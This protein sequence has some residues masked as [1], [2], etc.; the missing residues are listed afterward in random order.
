MSNKPVAIEFLKLASGGQ[1]VEAYERYVASDFKHHNPYFSNDRQSL[2]DGMLQSAAA[3]PNKS[4]EIIQAVED[5]DTV[6]VHSRLTRDNVGVQYAVVHILRFEG[7]K[8][9]EMWDIAQE[10]PGDSPNEVGMF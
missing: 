1:V 4:F 5:S 10:V 8:I 3:E 2:I 6:A 9:S 7:G